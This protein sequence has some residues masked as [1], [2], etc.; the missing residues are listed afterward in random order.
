M[1]ILDTRAIIDIGNER[2]RG[3]NIGVQHAQRGIHLIETS[4]CVGRGTTAAS[5]GVGVAQREARRSD[6][7]AGHVIGSA[8]AQCRSGSGPLLIDFVV[9]RFQ[10]AD[11][12]CVGSFRPSSHLR[13]PTLIALRADGD[14][15][16][17]CRTYAGQRGATR[18]EGGNT[19]IRI[20]RTAVAEGNTVVS[21]GISRPPY[22]RRVLA[23]CAGT[24]ADSCTLITICYRHVTKGNRSGGTGRGSVAHG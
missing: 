9:F 3:A 13:E 24:G 20:G 18:V 8:P 4:T 6:C 10:L 2:L 16:L 11:V 1:E 23:T 19:P 17:G 22:R 5:D 7:T 12:D 14:F 21:A 15:S